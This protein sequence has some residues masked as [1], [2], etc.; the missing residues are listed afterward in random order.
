MTTLCLDYVNQKIKACTCVCSKEFHLRKYPMTIV[1]LFSPVHLTH[2][3]PPTMN[4]TAC[5]WLIKFSIGLG[6]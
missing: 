1:P 3:N 6:T 4:A 2:E 5:S